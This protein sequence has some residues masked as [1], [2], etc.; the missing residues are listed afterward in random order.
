MPVS[1]AAECSGGVWSPV[2][3]LACH[4]PKGMLQ[5]LKGKTRKC[6]LYLCM[7]LCYIP[8]LCSVESDNLV[9][10][11]MVGILLLSDNL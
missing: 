8:S 3:S 5:D 4:N 2:L 7:Q 10:E 1:V 6:L 9:K 11:R